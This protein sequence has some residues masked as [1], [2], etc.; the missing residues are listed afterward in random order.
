MILRIIASTIDEVAQLVSAEDSQTDIEDTMQAVVR[1]SSNVL[2]SLDE[3][4]LKRKPISTENQQ[5]QANEVQSSEKSSIAHNAMAL[6]EQAAILI[7]KHTRVQGEVLSMK[8]PGTQLEV[9]RR[10]AGDVGKQGTLPGVMF[11]I[12]PSI[13]SSDVA[14]EVLML[15]IVY[16]T[17]QDDEVTSK[18]FSISFHQLDG[19]E[20]P[21]NHLPEHEELNYSLDA[22]QEQEPTVQR[23]SSALIESERYAIFELEVYNSGVMAAIHVPIYFEMMQQN[24]QQDLSDDSGTIEGEELYFVTLAL[25]E[26]HDGPRL[27]E[28]KISLL[29]VDSSDH[30][31]Y[32]AF[33]KQV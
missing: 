15:D 29:D 20:I 12:S 8:L 26:G 17:H 14:K 32:T 5:I 25:Y 2:Q 11:H 3:P 27:L 21:I 19:S 10:E 31:Q 13:I 4:K 1:T 9:E 28:K 33:I 22:P 6:I 23:F 7:F 30:L 18:V 16:E 24:N